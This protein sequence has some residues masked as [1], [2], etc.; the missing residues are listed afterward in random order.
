[1]TKERLPQNMTVVL[2]EIGENSV[3]FYLYL[4]TLDN[5]WTIFKQKL[6]SKFR[7]KIKFYQKN[8]I[9]EANKK[10]IPKEKDTI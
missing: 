3:L 4:L 10:L 6:P 8:G 5:E 2:Q 7:K 1:M 9:L